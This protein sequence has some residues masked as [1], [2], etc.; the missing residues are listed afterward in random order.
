LVF[1]RLEEVRQ[2]EIVTSMIL[3][4]ADE[5]T[6]KTSISLGKLAGSWVAKLASLSS[7]LTTTD[8]TSTVFCSL[9]QVLDWADEGSESE[10]GQSNHHREGAKVQT[11]FKERLKSFQVE[12]IRKDLD[13]DLHQILLRNLVATV[14]HLLHNTGQNRLSPKR[15]ETVLSLGSIEEEEKCLRLGKY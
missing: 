15:R 2:H 13:D 9:A 7:R 8:L 1:A 3:V 5:K 11:Y 12:V 6:L 4:M 10:R 14:D